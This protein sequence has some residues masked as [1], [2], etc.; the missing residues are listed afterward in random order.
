[1][2]MIMDEFLK[3][4]APNA[5]PSNP[6]I[7]LIIVAVVSFSFLVVGH[8]GGRDG[9][10]IR[11]KNLPR[12][13]LG[14]PMIGETWSFMR[15]MRANKTGRW[16]DERVARY[17]HVFKTNLMGSPTIVI[18]GDQAGQKF[19]LGADSV[20]LAMQQ[21][22]TSLRIVGENNIFELNGSRYK[23]VKGAMSRFLKPDSLQQYVGDIDDMGNDSIKVV[24]FLKELTFDLASSLLFGIYDQPT[25]DALFEDLS[26]VMKGVWSIPVNIPGT[27]YWQAIHARERINKLLLPIVR[28]RKD[29]VEGGAVGETSD[30]ISCLIAL[31]DENQQ[32]LDEDAILD[33]IIA[34]FLAS[35]DTTTSLASLL[36]WKLG[37]EPQLQEDILQEHID[38]LK[39]RRRGAESKMTW[40]EAQKMK[41]TWRVA[42]EMMRLVPILFGHNRRA[43]KDVSFEGYDIPKGWMVR[44][45]DSPT[46][47]KYYGMRRRS[48]PFNSSTID[49]PVMCTASTTH[50]DE[51]IFKDPTKFDPSRFQNPSKPIPPFTYIPFGAGPRVCPGNEF[52]RIETLTIIH[53][54]VMNFEWSLTTCDSSKST[55]LVSFFVI[56]SHIQKRDESQ[57]RK[58]NLPRGSHGLPMIGETW[59]FTRAMGVNKTSG[60]INEREK[61]YVHVF[62]LPYELLHCGD[63]R[64]RWDQIRSQS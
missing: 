17:G 18:A 48:M 47:R 2:V 5:S 20:A 61:R 11:K 35:H 30:V 7:I 23:Q 1:M 45:L 22:M 50:M 13:S 56:V 14:L 34:L 19:V 31:R 60:W 41:Y 25:K 43:I 10:Q 36:V 6:F 15:A 8:L 9:S 16:I 26:L 28:R 42:Q 57:I 63:C 24:P 29:L 38:I 4:L 59:S 44:V 64:S 21:P 39:E 33:N 52:A 49:A 27:C 32:A 12:G 37:M 58:K 55:G 51:G 53:H 62:N 3:S 54:L 40:S 46:R